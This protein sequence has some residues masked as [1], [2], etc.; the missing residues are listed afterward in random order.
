MLYYNSNIPMFKSKKTIAILGLVLLLSA[1]FYFQ[2]GEPT[3]ITATKRLLP[4]YTTTTTRSPS[5]N[6]F[7][8]GKT[9]KTLTDSS[10]SS[11]YNLYKQQM[12][13]MFTLDGSPIFYLETHSSVIS[14]PVTLI[15]PLRNSSRMRYS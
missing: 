9:R 1:V 8:A 13:A 14:S 11:A 5:I 3:T 12:Q 10:A 2:G 6:N 15:A 4:S 7:C